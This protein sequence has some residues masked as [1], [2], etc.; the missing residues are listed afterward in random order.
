[1][2]RKDLVFKIIGLV[3]N[4]FVFGS[5]VFICINA[6]INGYR[7]GVIV[8]PGGD[9]SFFRYFTNLSNLY[10]GIVSLIVFIFSLIHIKEDYALP[11]W[12]RI[13]QLSAVTSLVLTFLTV[14]VF[15]G[16]T[17]AANGNNYFDMYMYDMFFF[18]FFNPILV[19]IVFL[20]FSKG[21]KLNWK[22]CLFGIIPMVLYAIFYSIVVLSGTMEDFYGFTF[23]GQ[24]W[25]IP[26]VIPVMLGVTYGAS[27]LS[28]LLYN[29]IHKAEE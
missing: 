15:V 6:P 17:Y 13:V 21:E 26:L 8:V 4:L 9:A 2:S 12:L 7:F 29:K 1:M 16:P 14:L 11:K 24:Y 27:F 19:F 10:A 18:H 25:V 3:I 28:S 22:E 20:F 23:G 5:A